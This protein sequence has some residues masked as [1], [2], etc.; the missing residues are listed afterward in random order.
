MNLLCDPNKH[1]TDTDKHVETKTDP[2]TLTTAKKALI[3]AIGVGGYYAYE[4]LKKNHENKQ[5]GD[6]K[7]C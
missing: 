6:K 7:M 5:P 4:H 2:D 1:M 3:A